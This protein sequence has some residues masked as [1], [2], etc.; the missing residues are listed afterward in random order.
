MKSRTGWAVRMFGL[1]L[2]AGAVSFGSLVIAGPQ[3]ALILQVAIVPLLLFAGYLWINRTVQGTTP[4][5]YQRRQARQLGEQFADVWQLAQRV[6]NEYEAGITGT[7]WERLNRHAQELESVGIGFDTETGALAVGGQDSD[8]LTQRVT[9]QSLGTLEEINELDSE[10]NE[11]EPWLLERFTENVR[12]RISSVNGSLNQ[13]ESVVSDF[14]PTEPSTVPSADNE[15]VSWRETASSLDDCYRE[16]DQAIERACETVQKAAADTRATDEQISL[17]LDDARTYKNAGEYDQA[18]ASVLQARD[19]LEQ[20]GKNTFGDQQEVLVSLIQTASGKPTDQYLTPVY[21]QRLKQQGE[22]LS[23]FDAALDIAELRSLQEDCVQTCLE[24]VQELSE[25]AQS[26]LADLNSADVPEGW[27]EQP[28]AVET[29]HV[30]TLKQTEGVEAFRDEFDVAVDSLL[31]ALDE[32]DKKARVVNMYP[33]VE[34]E[35]QDSLQE[36]GY[37]TGE[38]LPLERLEEKYLGLYWRKHESECTFDPDTP[39]L[40]RQNSTE[41][42]EVRVQAMFPEGGEERALKISI[43]G[44]VNRTA[45]SRAPLV[46]ESVFTEIPYGEYTVRVEPVS[47]GYSRVS[48]DVLIDS[49]TKVEAELKQRSLRNQVC[50]DVDIDIENN[51]QLVADQ[52]N[53]KF[54]K[55]DHLSTGMDGFHFD[56]ESIPCLA[57]TWAE[58]EGYD[59]ARRD[60]NIIVYDSEQTKKEIENVIEYNIPPG[61]TEPLSEVRENFLSTPVP[62][63]TIRELVKASGKAEMVSIDGDKLRRKH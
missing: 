17:S 11:L 56:E 49:D 25:Q 15:T 30:Q 3:V 5:E 59:T 51:L 38:E 34:S 53:T 55:H 52:F 45:Q 35:I 36:K 24:I 27:Y 2:I 62:D 16:A 10:I 26:A 61:D 58:Q 37:V 12:D 9:G 47:T 40:S 23:E 31:Q 19:T 28:R 4:V 57:V 1:V 14:E 44:R 8:G 18:V 22:E 48:Q 41:T 29:N 60:E 46:A 54:E 6:E 43:D 32:V 21:E 50:A 7:E 13:I 20:K 63:D 33:R 42:Y 39:R